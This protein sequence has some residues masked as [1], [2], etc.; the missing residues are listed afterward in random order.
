[1]TRNGG[2]ADLHRL[3]FIVLDYVD[4]IQIVARFGAYAY[5]SAAIAP[6]TDACSLGT[7]L[8]KLFNQLTQK[9][10]PADIYEHV[11]A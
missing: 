11:F 5:F 9:H 6:G 4:L 1:M 10:V 8:T 7:K 2:N 3:R